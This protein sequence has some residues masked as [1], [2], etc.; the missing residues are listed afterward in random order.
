LHQEG[1]PKENPYALQQHQLPLIE[2]EQ[3][4][5]KDALINS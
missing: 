4:I 5:S 3:E 1:S 2:I